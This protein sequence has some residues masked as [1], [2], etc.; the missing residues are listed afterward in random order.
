QDTPTRVP[1]EVEEGRQVT[2]RWSAPPVGPCQGVDIRYYRWALDIADLLDETPRIDE[3]TDLKHW[4]SRSLGT[5]S[6]T[7]GPFRLSNPPVSEGHDFYVEVGDDVGTVSLGAVRITVV[8]AT[9]RP[10]DCSRA[11]AGIAASWPP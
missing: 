4:S 5:T 6:A 10:P 2:F 1:I 8:P 11:T 9:N 3:Q 7:V